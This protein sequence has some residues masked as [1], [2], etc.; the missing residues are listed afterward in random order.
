MKLL[1]HDNRLLTLLAVGEFDRSGASS[2]KGS[3]MLKCRTENG[4]R[5]T[6]S[7]HEIACFL[8][9]YVFPLDKDNAQTLTE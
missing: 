9:S 7:V 6:I 4:K 5:V 8:G 2:E 3:T 1:T